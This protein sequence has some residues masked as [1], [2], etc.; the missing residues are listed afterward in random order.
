MIQ[1]STRFILELEIPGLPE[2]TNEVLAMRLKARMSRKRYW[3]YMVW[4]YTANT[5]PVRPLKRAKLTLIRCSTTRPDPDGLT[6]TFKHIIDGLVESKILE[7]DRYENIGFPTY[8]WER[9]PANHGKI[10]VRVEEI[11]P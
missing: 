2:T 9:A 6:S 4:A 5:K 11:E 8:D 1:A 7:N 3:K 10:K